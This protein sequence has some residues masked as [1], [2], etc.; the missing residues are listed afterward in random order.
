MIK[1]L[2]V[3]D[4]EAVR[5]VLGAKL[6]EFSHFHVVGKAK[7][8][9]QA[10]EMI[11]TLQPDVVTL[12]IHMPKID[13][14]T[15]LRTIRAKTEIPVIMLSSYTREGAIVTLE[16]LRYGAFDFVQKP[17]GSPEDFQ[18]MMDEVKTKII[19]AYESRL[20][21]KL[22]KRYEE[23]AEYVR[24]MAAKRRAEKRVKLIAI[25]S[26]TGGTQAV[27]TILKG[28]PDYTPPILVVQHMPSPFT[29]LFAER[30]NME[31]I[32]EVKEASDGEIAEQGTVLIAPGGYHMRVNPFKP[33]QPISVNVFPSERIT[34]HIPSVNVLFESIADSGFANSSIGIIL[35]G[36]GKDGAIGMEKM[37]AKGSYTIGQD[38]KTCVV[39]GMPK[40]AWEIGALDELVPLE[41][42]SRKIIEIA[43][44]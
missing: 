2:I 33:G 21:P 25:G 17:D 7:D 36:M 34:G 39:F 19:S 23:V 38:E 18:R 1:I 37:K 22:P 29:K 27:E 26:S 31:V 11:E 30:L 6:S 20:Q 14:I 5:E 44:L 8:G 28:L 35:T 40:E 41:R 3:D 43:G 15:L 12:D 13:G 4:Q 10:L 42:I 16:A 9:L 32:L 24:S